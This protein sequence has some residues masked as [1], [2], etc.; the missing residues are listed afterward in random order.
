M[1]Y[2]SG[3][4][5]DNGLLLVT[6]DSQTLF[7][8]PR[9]TIQASE[10]CTCEVKIVTKGP[11][12][13]AAARSIAHASGSS[14]SDLKRGASL[15]DVYQRHASKRCRRAV[16]LKPVGPVIEQ[17][18]MVKSEEE[19]ARIRRSVL[20]NSEAFEKTVRSIRPG[21]SGIRHR[22]RARIPDAAPGRRESRLRNHRRHRTAH[23][24]CRT[25]SPLRGSSAMMNYY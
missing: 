24:R 12:D 2:L 22:G 6:P 25:R 4:T 13:Q 18:R 15:Y 21:V 14:A 10:E 11:L 8:D 20:T 16:T 17:L 1:R 3:F 9:F 23:P 19:I 5:G 7:T